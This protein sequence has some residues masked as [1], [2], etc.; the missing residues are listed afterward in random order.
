M[1][2][3]ENKIEKIKNIGVILPHLG[4]SQLAHE[5]ITK[6]NAERGCYSLYYEGLYPAYTRIH[7]S[8]MNITESKYFSGRLISTTLSSAE[9]TLFSLQHIELIYYCYDLEFLRG[10]TDYIHNISI[11]R[12]P[13][14]KLFTRCES[15]AKILSD[16]CNKEVE[17]CQIGELM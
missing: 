13:K 17:V 10:K 5:V 8:L 11:Y 14:L 15:Y 1:P 6:V 3:L 2:I 4:P 16:Y 9:Y 7:S 12:N